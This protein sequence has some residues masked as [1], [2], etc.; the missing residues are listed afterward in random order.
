[1]TTRVEAGAA[2]RVFRALASKPRREILRL[3]ATGAG[4]GDPRCCGAFDV[5]ACRFSE[6]LGLSAST[7]SHHMHALSE[8]GLVTSRKEGLWVYYRIRPEALEAAI[9]D[10]SFLRDA[11]DPGSC[12]GAPVHA[13]RKDRS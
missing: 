11:V 12:C 10:L 2:D 7:V 6:E 5:C 13:R 8:A 3:L 9:G 1:M 4:E